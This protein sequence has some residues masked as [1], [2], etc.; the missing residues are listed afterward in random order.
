MFGGLCADRLVSV[1]LMQS[2][3]PFGIEAAIEGD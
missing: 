2:L 3:A 1:Q